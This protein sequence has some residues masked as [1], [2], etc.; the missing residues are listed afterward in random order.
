MKFTLKHLGIGNIFAVGGNNMV[1][2]YWDLESI[3]R[4]GYKYRN[5]GITLMT[6]S[7]IVSGEDFLFKSAG[8]DFAKLWGE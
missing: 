5:S 2:A 7:K 8:E 4:E 1:T 3:N 6:N